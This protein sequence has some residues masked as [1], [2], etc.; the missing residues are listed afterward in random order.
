MI[1][2]IHSFIHSYYFIKYNN[3]YRLS[4]PLPS[5][6]LCFRSC[7]AKLWEIGKRGRGKENIYFNF[8]S[9]CSV[10]DLIPYNR[11]LLLCKKKKNFKTKLPNLS[12]HLPQIP[13]LPPIP[14]LPHQPRRSP[15][16]HH[17]ARHHHAARH[18]RPGQHHAAFLQD[19]ESTHHASFPDHH[20]VSDRGRFH[21]GVR[22]DQDVLADSERVVG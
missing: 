8:I 6:L 5:S 9:S 3:L 13:S 15:A 17:P 4:T 1:H 7:H 16:G 14:H 19:R 22:A 10:L 2:F 21:H 12:P 18:H 11:I 20:P